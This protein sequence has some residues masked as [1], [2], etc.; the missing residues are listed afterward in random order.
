MYRLLFVVG[1]LGTLAGLGL[2]GYGIRLV[3]VSGK[4]YG[5]GY[6]PQGALLLGPSLDALASIVT[7]AL[8]T[9]GCALLTKWFHDR[10]GGQSG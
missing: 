2:V 1:I 10:D 7:G 6:E 3:Y 5:I 4:A 8:I 9:A